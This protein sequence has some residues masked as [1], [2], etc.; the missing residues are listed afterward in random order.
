[1]SPSRIVFAVSVGFGFAFLILP[2]AIVLP[3]AFND[4]TFLNY[5]MS[6]VSLR[7]FDV[8]LNQP[9]WLFAMANSFKVAVGAMALSVVTGGLAAMGVMASGRVAALVLSALFVSPLVVPSVVL[10]VAMFFIFARFGLSGGHLSLILAHSVLGAPLVFLSAMTSL[11]GL[12]PELDRAGA[13]MGASRLFRFRTI[14]LPLTAPGFL[15]G[16]MFAFI[17]S[18][19]EVVVALFL[20]SP[21]SLT[22]PIALFSGLRDQLEPTLVVV[23]LMLSMISALFLLVV[24]RLQ[25]AT[26]QKA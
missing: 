17:T 7:W 5:P 19:D 2:L 8:V 12:N 13:S 14:I 21:Q 15:I 6:G 16:A 11:K 25:K 18:F 1:M 22:L 9:P 23:A 20:S 3:L 26:E 24:A 10:G 4:S